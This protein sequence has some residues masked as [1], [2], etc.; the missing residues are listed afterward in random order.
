MVQ[1]HLKNR[2]CGPKGREP[3]FGETC[4][5]TDGI[6]AKQQGRQV[7]DADQRLNADAGK[8]ERDACKAFL[9]TTPLTESGII[10]GLQH[11]AQIDRDYGQRGHLKKF[12][13]TLRKSPLL[14]GGLSQKHE[15]AL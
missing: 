7:S 1:S 13:K 15:V 2:L 14:D 6:V 11:A 3:V 8:M 10:A 5:L 12:V 4:A 9:K